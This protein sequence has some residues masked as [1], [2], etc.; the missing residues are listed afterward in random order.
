MINARYTTQVPRL[1]HFS[2]DR[3]ISL[4]FPRITR[5]SNNKEPAVW[6]IDERHAPSYWF[7]RECPRA[8]C[9]AGETPLS[10]AGR[11]LLGLGGAQRLHAI[12]AGWLKRVR[13]C[14][15]YAYEFDSH[16]FKCEVPEAGYW[17][18]NQEIVP[19]S[20]TSIG[21]LLDRHIEAGIEFRIVRNLWPLIDAIIAA[22]LDFSIIRK[23]NAQPRQYESA[24][25]C[26]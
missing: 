19:L 23:A 17:T 26:L 20:V 1:F 12:E 24:D 14:R 7:P 10:D 16:S 8:C 21:D 11:L 9:W 2:E 13:A 3:T 25:L 15:L 22:S 6:A 5:A 4:F 18:A